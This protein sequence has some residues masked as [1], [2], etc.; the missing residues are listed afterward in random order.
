MSCFEILFRNGFSFV[1]ICIIVLQVEPV[2]EEKT[3]EEED[4]EYIEE[5]L[6]LIR[7]DNFNLKEVSIVQSKLKQRYGIE[8]VQENIVEG[9]ERENEESDPKEDPGISVAVLEPLN[10]MESIADIGINT[11][12]TVNNSEEIQCIISPHVVTLHSSSHFDAEQVSNRQIIPSTSNQNTLAN[13]ISQH[14]TVTYVDQREIPSVDF[15][16]TYVENNMSSH[17]LAIPPRINSQVSV[18]RDNLRIPTSVKRTLTSANCTFHSLGSNEN[19]SPHCSYSGNPKI[20]MSRL[21]RTTSCAE[22]DEHLINSS[23][24]QVRKCDS[25]NMDFRRSSSWIPRTSASAERNENQTNSPPLQVRKH[26]SMHL[27][28]RSSPLQSREEE[29]FLKRNAYCHNRDSPRVN[30]NHSPAIN[31]TFSKYEM[32]KTPLAMLVDNQLENEDSEY[33]RGSC[34]PPMRRTGSPDSARNSPFFA[35]QPL[36]FAKSTNLEPMRHSFSDMERSGTQPNMYF[37]RH[38]EPLRSYTP[39]WPECNIYAS[40]DSDLN[41]Y[42]PLEKSPDMFSCPSPVFNQHSQQTHVSD[43]QMVLNA[44]ANFERV[45]RNLGNESDFDDL[46]EE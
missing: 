3:E 17:A 30:I 10:Q 44:S 28:L 36:D 11:S 18:I 38:S 9:V 16:K 19:P 24:P 45:P 25:M 22:R 39:T 46:F 32:R 8:D 2:Y 35:S 4:Q 12:E 27:D 37:P 33:A 7:S 40:E 14:E 5:L 6:E 34:I 43:V 31:N 42:S 15:M 41:R 26:S 29:I 1:C 20:N 23:P 13:Q 21:S